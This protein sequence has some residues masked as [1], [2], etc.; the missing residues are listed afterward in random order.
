MNNVESSF[1]LFKRSLDGSWHKLSK[2][3]LVRYLRE[4]EYRHNNRKNLAIFEATLSGIAVN[5]R[6]TFRTLVDGQNVQE[7]PF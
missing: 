4:M 2:K 7:L 1:S 6:L 5:P 3:H